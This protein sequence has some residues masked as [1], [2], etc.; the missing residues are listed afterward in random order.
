LLFFD[1]LPLLSI[2]KTLFL[3]EVLLF[4]RAPLLLLL[5]FSL[6][7]LP[8]G[9]FHFTSGLC[10]TTTTLC[11]FWLLEFS[12]DTSFALHIKF[13]AINIVV[14]GDLGCCGAVDNVRS[15]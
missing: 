11:L 2:P 12:D 3:F 1:T 15:V 8:R 6:C 4:A 7:P 5:S 13:R 9:F 14:V 10:Y